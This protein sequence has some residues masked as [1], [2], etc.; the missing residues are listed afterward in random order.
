MIDLNLLRITKYRS[1]FF[2][3]KGRVPESAMDAQTNVILSDFGYYFEK[4]PEHTKI[5]HA[6]F[7]PLFRSRHPT[8]SAEQRSAYEG[9][10]TNAL[11]VDVG[12]GEKAMIMR[13]MLELRLGT[14]LAQALSQFDAGDLPNIQGA[15][16][17]MMDEFKA[18]AG[19][20]DIDYIR[21][22]I[23]DLL[24]EEVN[25][26]G[27][28]W[29][30]ECMNNH[31]RG[32]RAGDFGIVA[33]RPDRGKTTFIASELTALASQLPPG[34]CAIWLNNEGPGK[35]I[36]PRLYQAALGAKTSELIALNSTGKLKDAYAD[37]MGAIDRIRVID[38][39]NMDNFTVETIVERNNPGIV[40][41]DMIDNVRGFGDAARTDLGLER[42]YQWGR[43][44]AVKHG[45]AGIATSQ[46][47]NEGDGLQFPT[48]S[49]LKDSKTG[50]QGA[51]DF[52]IM[53]GASNDPGL[54]NVRYIGTPKNK[55]RREGAS[56]DPRATVKY[57]PQR[58][59]YEDIPYAPEES[60]EE[61]PNATAD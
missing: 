20:Q 11:T 19:I 18:D 28:R 55:L 16:S 58:A 36:I 31:L 40:V 54:Q 3:V 9:I 4:L 15:L 2:K 50:K 10:L 37:V 47:S 39:H 35:R 1:D 43:E 41:Y 26:S 12:E 49:M 22:D 27:W 7:L 59:R 61:P 32:L 45:H 56:P 60:T 17:R 13:S 25:D 6:T 8:L 38:I 48:M 42:M 44:L 53:I 24:A 5:D 34:Q 51:C 52:M 21:D 46:I 30:L 23:G 14:Q 29:R 33:G 57:D